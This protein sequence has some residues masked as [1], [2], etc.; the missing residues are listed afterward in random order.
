MK[1]KIPFLSWAAKA[2]LEVEIPDETEEKFQLRLA[3][4]ISVKGRADLGGADL[5]GADLKGAKWTDSITINHAPIQISIPG[6]WPVYILDQHMQVGCEIHTFENWSEFDDRRILAMGS[7]RAL[8]F[9][10]VY[11]PALM[12]LCETRKRE[13]A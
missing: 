10:R 13:K 4:E 2:G 6:Y 7:R 9:W 12:A 5:G 3:L 8:E 11:K 1:V